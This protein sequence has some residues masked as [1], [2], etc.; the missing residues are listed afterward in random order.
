MGYSPW[1]CKEPDTTEQLNTLSEWAWWD[2][3]AGWETLQGPLKEEC[4]KQGSWAGGWRL[5]RYGR[6]EVPGPLAAWAMLGEWAGL[7]GS[8]PAGHVHNPGR[9]LSAR[10]CQ[11]RE[12]PPL[13]RRPSPLGLA[14]PTPRIGLWTLP[15][16]PGHPGPAAGHKELPTKWFAEVVTSKRCSYCPATSAP[17][18]NKFLVKSLLTWRR[19]VEGTGPGCVTCS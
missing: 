10:I 13:V 17:E 19:W 8:L 2:W 5:I 14:S 1:G 15:C 9:S 11:S 16:G 6:G 3:G 18:T 4:A 7:R 12:R